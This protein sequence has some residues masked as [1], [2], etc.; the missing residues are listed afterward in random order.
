MGEFN[1]TYVKQ[2][3]VPC[4]VKMNDKYF[5]IPYRPTGRLLIDKKYAESIREKYK[6][7]DLDEMNKQLKGD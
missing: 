1:L 3:D 2:Q 7:I 6:Y 5:L 4:V